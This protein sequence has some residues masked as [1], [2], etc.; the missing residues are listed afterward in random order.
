MAGFLDRMGWV[1]DDISHNVAM[2]FRQ[3]VE[4]Y[5]DLDTAELGS[6]HILVDR[7]GGMATL[8]D[9][10]GISQLSGEEETHR[11]IERFASNLGAFLAQSAYSIQVVF[12]YDP[13]PVTGENMLDEFAARM[14]RGA[15]RNG[16]TGADDVIEDTVK[17]LAG[18]CAYE[19]CTLVVTTSP[20]L[21][22]RKARKDEAERE[23]EIKKG[24]PGGQGTQNPRRAM[25]AVTDAHQGFVD[26]VNTTLSQ[27]GVRAAVMPAPE[28]FWRI[29]AQVDPEYTGMGW[30]PNLPG[31]PVPMT[32]RGSPDAAANDMMWQSMAGQL[33]PRDPTIEDLRTIS[34]GDRRYMPVQ[35]ERA[36]SEPKPFAA[37]F[38]SLRKTQTPYRISFRL[39]GDALAQMGTRRAV[40]SAMTFAGSQNKR[41]DASFKAVERFVRDERGVGVGLTIDAVTWCEKSQHDTLRRRFNQLSAA[42][43]SWGGME[44]QEIV[45]SPIDAVTASVAA[46]RLASPSNIAAWPLRR[47]LLLLPLTRPTSPFPRGNMLFRSVD[48][49][50]LPYRSFSSVQKWWVTMIFAPMGQG[51]SVLLN[52][53]N[54]ALCL[55]ETNKD[56]PIIRLIDIGFSSSGLVSLLQ[57]CLPPKRRHEALYS[58][59]TMGPESAI[60]I[61]DTPL[62][63]RRPLAAHHAFLVDLMTL[64]AT[65]LEGG[66]PVDGVSGIAYMVVDMAF[67]RYA[68]ESSPKPYNR[69]VETAVDHAIDEQGI[70]VDDSTTWWELV[71]ALFAR[72]DHV[73]AYVAQARAMPLLSECAALA[74]DSAITTVYTGNAPTGEALGDYFWRMMTEAVNNYPI[75]NAPTKLNFGA[76]RVVSLDLQD[77]APSGASGQ[78][79]RQTA[80]MYSVAMW[81]LTSEF[82]LDENMLSRIPEYCRDYHKAR[83][84]SFQDTKK[85]VGADEFHR[86]EGQSSVQNIFKNIIREGRKAGVE[87]VLASQRHEDFPDFMIGLSS[88]RFVL[89]AESGQSESTAKRIGLG[90]SA[91]AVIE[92]RLNGPGPGGSNLLASYRTSSGVYA[93][94][95]TLTLG[96]RAL[97]AFTSSREDVTLRNN[98]YKRI[99]PVAAREVLSMRYPGGSVAKDVERRSEE[100]N[101]GNDY[102]DVFDKEHDPLAEIEKE[103]LAD[104]HMLRMRRMGLN[105]EDD[106]SST[107]DE[108]M[109][110]VIEHSE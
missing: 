52:A 4:G 31:D 20:Q 25:E 65:P 54:F 21:L 103:V 101:N 23:I 110:D 95:L 15:E 71:D 17:A 30:R 73:S 18:K 41:I 86:T 24:I 75:L 90:S 100:M 11:I 44:T 63:L 99:G 36:P 42:L 6:D 77:V 13:D 59:L 78:S 85:R 48:G 35:M 80:V 96:A 3:S 57:S 79:A 53:L 45:G 33:I 12:E 94:L 40:A 37:L 27:C 28:A 106:T 51:K 109:P 60:N 14:R 58:K 8:F 66:N 102:G 55:D 5:C 61:L 74:K 56:L 62:C 49:K 16:L 64:F 67:E 108:D 7:R 32:S 87:T 34:I 89:G 10:E 68:D 88:T 50:L 19:R 104:A 22:R 69:G 105:P 9:L 98:L 76:A 1:L 39:R 29:R 72:K 70:E 91:A 26:Q 92:N 43:Q 97:W 82:L 83:I 93:H 107:E 84:H 46:L 47:A 2:L 38:S 81:K